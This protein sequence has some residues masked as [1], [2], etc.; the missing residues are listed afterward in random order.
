MGGKDA[1]DTP[2][3]NDYMR[4][5]RQQA[6]LGRDLIRETTAANRPNQYTPYGSSVWQ[7]LGDNRWQQTVELPETQ[8]AALESQ[9]RVGLGRSELA[10]SLLGRTSDEFGAPIQWEA[11]ETNELGTGADARQA[12]ED[13][14][15]GRTTSRLDPMWEQREEQTYNRLWNQGLRPGDEAW[16][17]AMA[18]MGRQR[19]DAYQ[20]AAREAAIY[21]G[22]EAERQFGMD[23]KRRQQAI[24]EQLQR[25]GASLNEINAILTG[26]QV[27]APGMPT[28][29]RAGTPAPP[30][31]M[32]A[33]NMGYQSELDRYNAQN[34]QD[35]G[36]M[37]GLLGIA[38]AGAAWAPF[39]FSD[40]RLKA[41]I[42]H[43]GHTLGRQPV[44]SYIMF[45]HRMIGV[46]ADESP[47]DA[48]IE[49]PSG[50]LMVDY[51]RIG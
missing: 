37:S 44:Y 3:T 23:F 13:A 26:Q 43:I 7:D 22:R 2:S 29:Q 30:D 32:G 38:N 11:M 16:D 24:A 20:T 49:H 4:V 12:A 15:Y 5:A 48:V 21:G 9:Q 17:T 42:R 34:M 31:L 36:L 6:N 18:N 39:M 33:M 1:P 28:F 50:Y 47:P 41:D 27:A 46:M 10:E 40:R 19:T 35:Q 51:S 8:Q 45:G 25:R 14:L